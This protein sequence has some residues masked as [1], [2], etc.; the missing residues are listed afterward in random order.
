MEVAMRNSAGIPGAAGLTLSLLGAVLLGSAAAADAMENCFNDPTLSTV[1]R[2]VTVSPTGALAYKVTIVGCSG[3][4]NAS[5]VEIRFNI[6][7]DTLICW[8]ATT[9]DPGPP[10]ATHSFFQ[11]TGVNG[12]AT[13]NIRAGGCRVRELIIRV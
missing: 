13:F 2:C 5:R 12:V 1:P 7:G 9:P 10:P 3:P 11:N 8:C 6:P 4:I